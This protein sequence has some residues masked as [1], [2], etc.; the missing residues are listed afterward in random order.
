MN[1]RLD[2]GFGGG[3]GGFGGGGGGFGGG[4]GG[5]GGGGGG[6]GNS[7][8]GFGSNDGDQG[9][10]RRSGGSDS[11]SWRGGDSK[12]TIKIE[13]NEVG[14]LIGKMKL[15]FFLNKALKI[16]IYTCKLMHCVSIVTTCFVD[17]RLSY[18]VCECSCTPHLSGLQE[19]DFNTPNLLK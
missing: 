7:R 1:F 18:K 10:S 15:F 11:R 9:G 13:N 2:N 14:R 3:G 8:G 4:G 17:H 12:E 16:L 19:C 6:F 5:F